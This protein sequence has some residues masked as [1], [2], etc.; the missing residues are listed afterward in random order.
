[1][2]FHLE[3]MFMHREVQLFIRFVR[4]CI[5]VNQENEPGIH[6]FYRLGDNRNRSN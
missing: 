4:E 2:R 1:M 6:I 5:S 3:A